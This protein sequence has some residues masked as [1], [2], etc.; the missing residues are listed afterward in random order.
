[1]IFYNDLTHRILCA[2]AMPAHTKPEP[3]RLKSVGWNRWFEV[4][5]SLGFYG[6]RTE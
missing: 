5:S 4:P 2:V 6:S 1:M 3:R